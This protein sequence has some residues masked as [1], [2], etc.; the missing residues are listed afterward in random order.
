MGETDFNENTFDIDN[1]LRDIIFKYNIDE[2]YPKYRASLQAMKCIRELSASWGLN[3]K[4]ACIT[5]GDDNVKND[6]DS[7]N[8]LECIPE[9]KRSQ[10]QF[11]HVKKTNSSLRGNSWKLYDYSGLN[12]NF[13]LYGHVY[14][15]SNYNAHIV[16]H[17]LRK[18]NLSYLFIYD[19]FSMC[20]LN[21]FNGSNEE[22]YN[23]IVHTGG[24]NF[25]PLNDG[26][27]CQEMHEAREL[28]VK[29]K[30]TSDASLRLLLL[31]KIFFCGIVLRNFLLAE[32]AEHN[33]VHLYPSEANRYEYAWSS[34]QI[35]FASVKLLLKKRANKNIISIW[36][37]C[38][39]YEQLDSMP[40]L[41]SL[42][43]RSI[44]FSNMITL[45]GYTRE[46]LRTLFLGKRLL[47]DDTLSIP[48]IDIRN[49]PV[50]KSLAEHH[51]ETKIIGD[52]LGAQFPEGYS[53]GA[54]Y[55]GEKTYRVYPTSRRLW[56]AIRQLTMHEDRMF[57]LTH[58]IMETHTP[59]YGLSLDD[60]L[61]YET[62]SGRRLHAVTEC[63]QQIEFY[64]DFLQ[65]ET[66]IFFNDHG[67]DYWWP[68]QH[69]MFAIH[70]KSYAPRCVDGLCSNI[71]FSKIM[72]SILEKKEICE[73][74]L[75]HEYVDIQGG[76]VRAGNVE[77]DRQRG[78]L[79]QA[80]P[81]FQ[82]C[83]HAYKGIVTDQHVY[84]YMGGHE[85]LGLRED[86]VSQPRWYERLEDICDPLLLPKF[87]K[88]ANTENGMPF[89]VTESSY[90]K[91]LDRVYK[92]ARKWNDGK[93]AL[94]NE[95][96]S[97]LDGKR[98]ALYAGGIATREFYYMLSEKNR[99]GV[100]CILEEIEECP[101]K[102][103]HLSFVSEK[104]IPSMQ[105][106][107]VVF[108][109]PMDA[110]FIRTRLENLDPHIKVVSLKEF[111][112]TNGVECKTDFW[113]FEVHADDFS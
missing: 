37:D 99:K 98:V 86:E 55:P 18:R 78:Y 101:C 66:C 38:I 60:H 19:Y 32:E 1:A 84:V 43:D 10:I 25:Q 51:I 69:I 12:Q 56:E 23:F 22:W 33:I 72:K 50:L 41:L 93:V 112:E 2:C 26:V 82:W 70:D 14:L 20:G 87:R 81:H 44:W 100:I 7:V 21:E 83:Y 77:A 40:F 36:V 27:Y 15:I 109:S 90:Y 76:N 13:S 91:A 95:M 102:E 75:V 79:P 35:L 8:F 9:N 4:I 48:K 110:S 94:V 111:F 73:E 46:T 74:E 57:L 68:R 105:I 104:E 103:L 3:E 34:I 89:S 106:D 67:G 30:S 29:Y 108:T 49:S 59:W 54:V 96:M 61:F 88:M 53:V 80:G 64:F 71:D 31:K 6:F 113:K 24:V 47:D 62:R 16:E 97:S 52:S 17:E 65:E 45:T 28:I 63:D 85:W 5:I 92:K 58:L 107:I 39:S 42:Q 11:F